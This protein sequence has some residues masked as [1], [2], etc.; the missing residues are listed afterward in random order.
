MTA[1]TLARAVAARDGATRMPRRIASTAL[2]TALVV[3]CGKGSDVPARP[4]NAGA[5]DLT[6]MA[7]DPDTR[8]AV[9]LPAQGR[10]L[11][12]TEMR[13]MLTSV[14]GFIAASAHR[15]TAGM[16]TAATASGMAAARDMDPAMEQ[17]LPAEFL[18]LGMS[19]H[20]AWDSLAADV[21]AGRPI[22]QTLDRLG[23]IMH[24]CV[25]CHTQFRINLQR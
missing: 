7:A 12:L 23:G 3:G 14:Q 15:D 9:V 19:T 8:T 25:A 4:G 1:T 6:A 18:R 20:A 22:D 10:H 24:N 17:R 2:L 11:V 16:R 13:G 5:S 21:G